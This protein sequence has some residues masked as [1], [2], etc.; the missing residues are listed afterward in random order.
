MKS[1]GRLYI[2]PTKPGLLFSVLFIVVLILGILYSNNLVLILTFIIFSI[3]LLSMFITHINLEQLSLNS[4]KLSNGYAQEILSGK[5]TILNETQRVRHK[6]SITFISEDEEFEYFCSS[7]SNYKLIEIQTHS[8]GRNRGIYKCYKIRLSTTYPLGLFYCWTYFKVNQDI[9]VYPKMKNQIE[10]SLNQKVDL[11]E[12]KVK[13]EFGSQ[14]FTENRKHLQGE[15]LNKVNWRLFA[16]YNELFVKEFKDPIANIYLLDFDNINLEAEER[17]EQ[18]SYWINKLNSK[19][20]YWI[21]KL[22][23]FKSK[24]GTG[25]SHFETCMKELSHFKV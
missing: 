1:W 2:I 5:F 10:L 13:D 15:A 7:D 24:V 25:P 3:L 18:L 16:K 6:F 17:L 22:K 11:E 20:E 23:N 21:L 4:F 12:S 9:C 19:N 14:E 8:N